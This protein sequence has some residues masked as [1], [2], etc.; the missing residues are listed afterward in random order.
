MAWISV[1]LAWGGLRQ[2]NLLESLNLGSNIVVTIIFD[3]VLFVYL[4]APLKAE[5]W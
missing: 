3:Y 2:E 4:L 1:I 5:L